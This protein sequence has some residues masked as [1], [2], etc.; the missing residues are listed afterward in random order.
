MIQ[1][2]TIKFSIMFIINL[3]P[4]ATR[5]NKYN[6]DNDNSIIRATYSLSLSDCKQSIPN[7]QI[8]LHLK[9]FLS[10]EIISL[11]KFNKNLGSK[12]IH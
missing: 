5:I 6:E 8:Q 4:I 12:H 3:K 9:I 10:V 11:E 1:P 2:A 7:K